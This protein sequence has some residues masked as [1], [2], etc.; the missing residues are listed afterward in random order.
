MIWNLGYT[1][2]VFLV[3]YSSA[4]DNTINAHSIGFMK[5]C[6]DKI[7]NRKEYVMK[8]FKSWTDKLNIRLKPVQAI[9]IML[10]LSLFL[11]M[12]IFILQPIAFIDVL[13]CIKA[14]NGLCFFLNW[15]PVLILMFFFYFVSSNTVL[16]AS[17]VTFICVLLGVINRFKIQLRNDPFLFWDLTLGAEV[18]NIVKNFGARFLITIAAAV[19]LYI[20]FSVCAGFLVRSKRLD[21]KVRFIGS[22]VCIGTALLLNQPLYKS[23]AI[24]EQLMVIGNVYNQVD[25]FISKGF[26]YSFIYNYNT[27]KVTKPVDYDIDA[28][29][30]EI[31]AADLSGIEPLKAQKKPHI[32]MIMEEAYSELA[33][34]PKID[35]SGYTDPMQHYREIKEDAIYGQLVVPNIGGGTADTE[36]DTL[37]GLSTRHFRGVPFAFRLIAKDFEAMPRIL[38]RI[39]YKSEAL[40]PGYAWFYNRQNA[41]HYLGFEQTVFI[42]AFTNVKTKGAYINEVATMDKVIDMFEQ[43]TNLNPASPYYLFCITIQNHGPY[44]DKYAKVTQNFSTTAA[45]DATDINAMSNYFEGVKDAD[46]QLDRIVQYF[47]R[48]EEPVVLIYFGDHLPAF[49]STVYNE[50]YPNTYEEGSVLDLTRL[51]HVPFIIWQN[52]AA[53]A[54]TPIDLNY[55]ASTDST[56]ELL[57]T[58]NYFGAYILQL[59]GYKH[60]S[61]LMDYLNDLRSHYPIVLEHQSFLSDHTS[62][63]QL[64]QDQQK[65]LKLYR[66]WSYYEIFDE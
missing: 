32:I 60:T 56:G 22:I 49:S 48:I 19:M 6:G 57:F 37:T 66:D 44:Q 8:K 12:F 16:S 34:N 18:I 42:D 29:K 9:I 59:L 38:N 45:I 26:I 36:F 28:V 46:E 33:L 52:P 39:G 50:F 62:S 43:N 13:Q 7:L 63:E 3:L 54:E 40:H 23:E 51:N 5:P 53:K 30:A 58:A 17:A 14:S 65:D 24:H 21:I 31:S 25:Q 55:A 1:V 47:E 11:A 10:L 20:F 27:N 4:C 15:L 61:P 2:V 35:F 64:T 41:F